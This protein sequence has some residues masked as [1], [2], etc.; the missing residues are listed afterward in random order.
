MRID[1]HPDATRELSDFAEWYAKRSPGAARDFA[2]EIERALDK[3]LAD[4]E[5]FAPTGTKFRACSVARFPFQI[6][7]DANSF[8]DFNF[9]RKCLAAH[10]DSRLDE[11]RRCRKPASLA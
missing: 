2:I 10:V 5:R 4:P 3:I 7:A 8:H 6:Y 9:I 11:K 1:F